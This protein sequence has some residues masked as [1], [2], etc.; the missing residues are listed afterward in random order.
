M[1]PL[2]KLSLICLLLGLMTTCKPGSTSRRDT[3][4]DQQLA[5][6][7]EPG[8]WKHGL[9]FTGPG[10]EAVEAI[11]WDKQGHLYLT[12]YFEDSLYIGDTALLSRAKSDLFLAKMDTSGQVLW[13]LHGM[14]AHDDGGRVL[15]LTNS[16]DILLA[17]TLSGAAQLGNI[18]IKSKG[19]Q[20]GFTAL[21]STEGK[22]NELQVIEGNQT[23]SNDELWDL[24][25][26]SNGNHYII[27]SFYN[28]LCVDGLDSI[29]ATSGKQKHS[30]QRDL[31]VLKRNA[32][33]K[34]L[35]IRQV[36]TQ[37]DLYHQAKIVHDRAGGCWLSTTASQDIVL[38][39]QSASWPKQE[40]T[41][42]V[43]AHIN[44]KGQVVH[45][46]AD[47]GEGADKAMGV[48][49]GSKGNVLLTGFV[50]GACSFDGFEAPIAGNWD[51]FLTRYS[52]GGQLRGVKTFGGQSTDQGMALGVDSLR[53]I[54]V[55]GVFKR[56]I[57]APN[58]EFES[59]GF[60]DV[61]LGKYSPDG[62]LIEVYTGGGPGE[63]MPRA[64]AIGPGGQV[65]VAGF[66][67]EQSQF[68]AVRLEGSAKKD[69]FVV[70]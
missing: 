61:F 54:Y 18:E 9:A 22:V 2:Q 28:T 39:D 3:G 47:G 48:C 46:S 67:Q 44:Q 20:D 66:F 4:L 35:W 1:A 16:G 32:E 51:M 68:G 64:L 43:L 17:G 55:A 25:C 6:A 24:S 11:L 23:E 60:W 45:L 56:S 41:N 65:A 57:T 26:D 40:Q 37:E 50:S 58:G 69:A 15:E 12:G 7:S 29:R 14:G 52:S 62:K 10:D 33:G 13:V 53:E 34:N 31:Y 30:Q 27:G 42:T 36:A 38:G 70:W 19:Y 59:E 49:M 5:A 8:F 21:I 63:D